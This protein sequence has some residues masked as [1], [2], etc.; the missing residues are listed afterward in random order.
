MKKRLFEFGDYTKG[1]STCTGTVGWHLGRLCLAVRR[2]LWLSPEILPTL[3]SACCSS[4]TRLFY[5]GHRSSAGALYSWSSICFWEDPSWTDSGI[6]SVCQQVGGC[7]PG[8]T[9]VPLA[10]FSLSEVTFPEGHVCLG[11]LLP[12]QSNPFQ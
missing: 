9:G 10:C 3:A 8:S 11:L 12:E 7:S 2:G 1:A 5:P 4:D 6:A